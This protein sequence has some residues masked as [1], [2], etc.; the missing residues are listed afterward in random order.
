MSMMLNFFDAAWA[1]ARASAASG[2]RADAL[3]KLNPLLNSPD[4]PPRLLVLAHRLAARLL[5]EV[6]RYAAARNQL[7]AAIRHDG[8]DAELRYELGVLFEN[9]P[10]GCDL[11]AARQF[12]RA[13]QLHPQH[14]K[15]MAAFGRALVRLNR[16]R[17]GV[18]NLCSAAIAAPADAKVLKVVVEGLC[19]AGQL[20]RAEQIVRLA[21]FRAPADRVF[22]G[23]E[24]D[25]R[26][27]LARRVAPCVPRPT[28]APH[29]LPFAKHAAGAARGGVMRRD[30]GSRP[31]PHMMRL[32]AHRGESL[33]S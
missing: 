2:H 6:G 16:V 24:N 9:D 15:Y 20:R 4:T 17:V 26:F 8:Y 3:A 33:G 30:M 5:A 7:R 14:P 1:S 25:L 23:L 18:R 22:R 10:L 21:R 29:M 12:R 13:V 28:A 19:D 32:R 31:A 27:A 11:R